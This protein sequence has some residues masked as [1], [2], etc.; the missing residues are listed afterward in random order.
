M[1]WVLKQKLNFVVELIKL[2]CMLSTIEIVLK[3]FYAFMKNVTL[4]I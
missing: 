3:K 2:K 1:G 4:K